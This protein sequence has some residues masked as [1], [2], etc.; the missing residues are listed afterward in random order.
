MSVGVGSF[1]ENDEMV[2]F[3]LSK[4]FSPW[5]LACLVRESASSSSFLGYV[6][7]YLEF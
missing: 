2:V 3:K 6:V 1:G 4:D 7:A 5:R